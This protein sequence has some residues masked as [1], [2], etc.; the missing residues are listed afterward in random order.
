MGV[1]PAGA[2]GTTCSGHISF[3][4]LDTRYSKF[5]RLFNPVLPPS[6][7]NTLQWLHSRNSGSP[8]MNTSRVQLTPQIQIFP[9]SQM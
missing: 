2:A 1:L 6:S 3:S 8:D 5:S 7:C 9:E 4:H